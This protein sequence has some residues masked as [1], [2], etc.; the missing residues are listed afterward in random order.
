[1]SADADQA[2]LV[3]ESESAS[4]EQLASNADLVFV[5][6]GTPLLEDVR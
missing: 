2:A 6:V 5:T 4:E 1:M 3:W